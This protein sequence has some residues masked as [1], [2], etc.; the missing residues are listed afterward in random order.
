MSFS[1]VVDV[2]CPRRCTLSLDA[3]SGD[4]GRSEGGQAVSMRA[5]TVLFSIR[6]R[7][8]YSRCRLSMRFLARCRPWCAARGHAA[9][10]ARRSMYVSTPVDLDACGVL[11]RAGGDEAV[12]GLRP[13]A[14]RRRAR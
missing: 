3:F 14:S 11:D 6:D 8:A 5:L 9:S 2:G 7:E 10:M 12:G 4:G 13:A 1:V